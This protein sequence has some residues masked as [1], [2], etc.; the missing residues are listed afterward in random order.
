M[1]TLWIQSKRAITVSLQ[2]TKENMADPT[3]LL[4]K[5]KQKIKNQTLFFFN[6][7]WVYRD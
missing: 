2:Y 4:G 5:Q 3:S 1:Y 7:Q 6:A